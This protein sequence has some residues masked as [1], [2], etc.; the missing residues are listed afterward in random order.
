MATPSGADVCGDGW[1]G[2]SVVVPPDCR[3]GF[4]FTELFEASILNVAP[5]AVFLLLAPVCA[6]QLV[7]KAPKVTSSLILVAKLIVAA[8]FAGIELALLALVATRPNAG[9]RVSV[10]GAV[11]GFVAALGV[12]VLT[13]IEHIKSIRPSFLLS[14]YLGVTVLLNVAT[15]RTAWLAPDTRAYSACLTASVAVKLLLLGL[16]TV[17]KRRWLVPGEKSKSSESTSGPFSR[18]IFAWLNGVLTKGYSALLAPHT[19]PAVHE[20]LGS[21]DLADRFGRAWDRCTQSH[22]YA[23]LFAIVKCLRWEIANIAFPRLCLVGLSIAQPFLIGRTVSVLQLSDELSLNMS[24]GLVGAT[25][26]VFIGAAVATSAYEHLGFR[27]TTMLRGGLMAVVYQKM[28]ALPLGTTSESSA[29]SLMGSDIEALADYFHATVCDTWANAFQLG[30]AVWLLQAQM[31]AV[32]IAPILVAIGFIAGSFAMGGALSSRQSKWLD[33]TEKRVNFTTEILG[34]MKNV[35]L[36]GLTEA[37]TAMIEASRVEELRVSKKYR[38]MQ[39]LRVCI[40]NLPLI[41]GQFVAFAAYAIVAKIQGS[42]N[43]SVTQAITSLSLINLLLLPLRDLLFA[44]PDTFSAIGCLQ[45]IQ[46]FLRLE[47]RHESRQLSLATPASSGRAS[48]AGHSS[49]VEL[50]RFVSSHDPVPK[51]E[52]IVSLTNAKFGWKAPEE[53]NTQHS[54]AGLTLSLPSSPTGTLVMVVGPVGSGKT[55]FLKGLAGETLMASG[56]TYIRYPDMAFCEQ[57]PWLSNDSVRDNIVGETRAGTLG[58]DAEWYRTVVEGCALGRDL[59]RMAPAG[60]ATL[61]GSKGVKLSG[62]QK[63]RISIARAVYSRKRIACFDDVLSGLDS[64]TAQAVFS[65]VFGPGGLLRKIGCTVFLATHSVHHLP[66]AD[67]IIVFSDN[68]QAI[69]Q[70]SFDQLRSKAG[71]YVQSLDIRDRPDVDAASGPALEDASPSCPTKSDS[72]TENTVS[73]EVEPAEDDMSR[74][75]TDFAVYKYYFRA[76]GWVRVSTL[77]AWL[78]LNTGAGTARYIWLNLWSSSPDSASSLRL[79]YWV[80]MFAT[81]SVLECLGIIM[82]TFWVWVIIVPAASKNLHAVVLRACMSAPMSFLSNVETG[83][84]VNRFSQDMRL[85][86]MVLPR[87]FVTTAFQ[88]FGAMG[89]LAIAVVAIPYLA[90]TLPVILGLLVLVQRFYLRTSR[91]LRLLEIELKAPLYTHFIQS[92][93]GLATIRAF[94]WTRPYTAKTL[95]LLDTAQKPYYLLL[96]IQRWLGLVLNLIVA[97]LTIL[98]TGMAVG[99]RGRIDP[100]LLGIALVVMTTLGQTLSQLIQSWTML[101]TSLGAIARIRNFATD[102][103]SEVGKP[104]NDEGDDKTAADSWP[105]HGEIEFKNA[106]ISYATGQDAKPVLRDISLAI[107]SGEKIGLCGRTGSGKSSLVLALLRLNELVSGHITI[108]GLDI[109]TVARPLIRQRISCLSQEPFIFPASI[110]K[111]ADPV[112]ASSDAEIVAALKRVGVWDSTVFA[113]GAMVEA[114]GNGDVVARVLDA[115]LEESTLSHGQRQLFCLARALL[116]RSRI[117]ILDEP[118]SSLDAQTDAKIQSVIRA[119]F[120]GCV[121][122]MVAHRMHTLLDF[123]RVAVVDS[124]RIIEL[125]APRELLAREGGAFARLSNIN[126]GE[127]DGDGR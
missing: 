12:S 7:K 51:D 127:D 39:T 5:A 43:L 113:T 50:S 49:S 33:A 65:G 114:G 95:R 110:R 78:I 80:G 6:I 106:T 88:V 116:K 37:M 73:L 102:T 21:A 54:T 121:V 31:G 14:L 57:T 96:C 13:Y 111:N 107:Q 119:A 63:Q 68:G 61:V 71:G 59:E 120:A 19:L 47:L 30:L 66:D 20:K 117:L 44:I 46:E 11:L 27:T 100:G 9:G 72:L 90:A 62:G 126:G 24:Y 70:G 75:T 18:G 89:E 99:L 10:A 98:M 42:S 112:G 76:L 56:E 93:N 22:K 25:A 48:S 67:H 40:V 16:E 45:R 32:C 101:E 29:M 97:G 53:T 58:F 125:G 109:S 118:T 82:A 79:G 15:V 74:Q 87:G 124:G 26:I 84:L 36:L 122:I 8:I 104:D 52:T 81:L 35:K 17:E 1:F 103:P 60:D 123:D 115:P 92:L 3:G 86:D 105:S 4:D 83:L 91:Q 85:V 108:D 28:M 41:V 2:P 38:R 55:T 64:A 69:E 77:A 94:T 34:A 23:L